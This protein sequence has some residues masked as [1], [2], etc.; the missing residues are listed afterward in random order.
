MFLSL[1]GF[2]RWI[3]VALPQVL[4]NQNLEMFSVLLLFLPTL[5]LRV[6]PLTFFEDR[7]E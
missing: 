6:T 4:I 1:I 7:P 2:E 5:L 3:L